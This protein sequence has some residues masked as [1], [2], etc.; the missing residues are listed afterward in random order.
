MSDMSLLHVLVGPS[1]AHCV[2]K[3]VSLHANHSVVEANRW[4][5]SDIGEVNHLITNYC[6][7]VCGVLTSC[8]GW[9]TLFS[10]R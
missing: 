6:H 10:S 9:S 1:V 3:V 2:S 7:E 8:F 5:D 4:C